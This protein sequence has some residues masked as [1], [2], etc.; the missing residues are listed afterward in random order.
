MNEHERRRETIVEVEQLDAAVAA[1]DEPPR[2]CLA[3]AEGFFK[4]GR[5]H[6]AHLSIGRGGKNRAKSN[7][8]GGE[9]QRRG[10]RE[11]VDVLSP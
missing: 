4:I 11:G 2:E 6:R 10:E 3:A 7:T 8:E 5:R 1:F 9:V